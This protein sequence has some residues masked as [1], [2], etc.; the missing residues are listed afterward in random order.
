MYLYPAEIMPTCI[1]SAGVA[2][3]YVVMHTVMIVIVQVAPLALEAIS[4]RFFLIFLVANVA[5]VGIL[6]T[7]Y[8]ETK[9]KTLEEIGALFGDEVAET[10]E[11]AGL[12]FKEEKQQTQHIERP[13]I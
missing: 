5:F 2:T 10:L 8:P 11:E 13:L 9:S 7:F 1:R 6:Y 3:A 12:H 4:W